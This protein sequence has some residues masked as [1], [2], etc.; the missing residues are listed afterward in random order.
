MA[1][2]KAYFV[3]EKTMGETP[4]YDPDKLEIKYGDAVLDVIVDQ[5]NKPVKLDEM[6][7]ITKKNISLE[8]RKDPIVTTLKKWGFTIPPIDKKI[9][10]F[11]AVVEALNIIH[12][13]TDHSKW[14]VNITKNDRWKREALGD[15][16]N[17]RSFLHIAKKAGI[18]GESGSRETPE[19]AKAKTK[20][21]QKMEQ[22]FKKFQG[23]WTDPDV[24]QAELKAGKTQQNFV[25]EWQNVIKKF[26]DKGSVRAK[27]LYKALILLDL[28]PE[29]FL[30]ASKDPSVGMND[31]SNTEK[32]KW[33]TERMEEPTFQAGGKQSKQFPKMSLKTWSGLSRPVP[34][35]VDKMVKNEKTG[36]R[37]MKTV[38][39]SRERPKSFEEGSRGTLKQLTL[40]LRHLAESHGVSGAWGEIWSQKTPIAKK[41]DLNLTA[42]ELEKF[43]ECLKSFP[44]FDE[45][46]YYVFQ[47][48]VEDEYEEDGS[49]KM[50]TFRSTKFDW[51]NAYLYYK[52]GM[53]MGWR[54][55]EAFTA[56][57]NP[58]KN[59]EK[60][61]GVM[62]EG[63]KEMRE[64]MILK[65]DYGYKGAYVR[66]EM[67]K[68]YEELK[69]KLIEKYNERFPDDPNLAR[70][71]G[72]EESYEI[73]VNVQK[74]A[75]VSPNIALQIM[76]RKTAHVRDIIHKGFIQNEETKALIKAKMEKIAEGVKQPTQ[77][78]ADKFG[79]VLKYRD[80]SV[81]F[82]L[83]KWEASPTYG[84]EITN[85]YHSL[86]GDDGYYVKVGTMQ[87]G[88]DP[89]FD[90]AERDLFKANKW[91]IPK[92][93]TIGGNRNLLTAIFRQCYKQ[94]LEEGQVLD[95]Y[96]L[97][98]SLHA[99][100]HLF[101][102]YWIKASDK[103]FTFVKDLGHWGGT[104]VLENFYGRADSSETLELQIKFGKK[105]FSD[106]AKIEEDKEKTKDVAEKTNK[107]MS[108]ENSDGNTE[109]LDDPEAEEEKKKEELEQ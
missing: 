90:K 72:T 36:K 61:S 103:D 44:T 14:G 98:H 25:Y 58:P 12:T 76:T 48:V 99:I 39:F 30:R 85:N 1:N 84:K 93:H 106:L 89:K 11:F 109:D 6:N 13:T 96:F 60:D 86:I 82:R 20:P 108:D 88:A 49:P 63:W 9:D 2:F 52:V 80:E 18:L 77:A 69:E 3:T 10:R 54:R 29:E 65:N 8:V 47:E 67:D 34:T 94:A 91:T 104:D 4:Y 24:Y 74:R 19:T 31:K 75:I 45:D 79:V 56:V 57:G 46:G 81:V 87:Y 102:Q 107:F 66:E 73:R 40:V 78:K 53:D 95:N 55:E 70:S 32:I 43:A 23:D 101:A 83:G 37:E 41:G 105:K 7:P 17:I 38:E 64:D 62:S 68:F 26:K 5:D 15:W 33:L 97:K 28:S 92:V 22:D 35:L 59:A 21:A 42:T 71:K 16:K 50:K 27:T 51:E 100:R